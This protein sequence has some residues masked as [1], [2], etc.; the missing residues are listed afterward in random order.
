MGIPLIV[1]LSSKF[2][3][4]YKYIINGFQHHNECARNMVYVMEKSMG[5]GLEFWGV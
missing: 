2:T 1:K 5:L 4:D 3:F